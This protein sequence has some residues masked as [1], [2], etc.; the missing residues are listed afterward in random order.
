MKYGIQLYTLREESKENFLA[1]LEHV[2]KCGYEGVEFAGY[3]GFTAEELK[4]HLDRLGLTCSSTHTPWEEVFGNP[5]EV[6]AIH[7]ALGCSHVIVP[8]YALPN[9]ES[10]YEL[11]ER[12]NKVQALYQENGMTLGYHNHWHEFQKEGDKFL[13]EILAEKA[14]GIELEVDTYWST[15][16]GAD[17][18]AFLHKHRDRISRIHLKDGN[19][20]GLQA[21]GEGDMD[22]QAVINAAKEIGTE[23][24]VVENDEPKPDGFSDSARSMEN[25][26]KMAI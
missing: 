14:P 5:E 3:Y 19:K 6:I 10:V 23:W 2:A 21:I 22:I 24:A 4:G 25:L 13:L 8:G 26:K 1:V 18:I 20:D 11:A 15:K 12:F 7:K 9:V 16:G 17:T